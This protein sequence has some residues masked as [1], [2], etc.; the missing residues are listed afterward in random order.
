MGT[1]F[2]IGVKPGSRLRV[3]EDGEG[4]KLEFWAVKRERETLQTF[5]FLPAFNRVPP[6]ARVTPRKVQ[7]K[8]DGLPIHLCRPKP[9]E[10]GDVKDV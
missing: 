4:V 2:V 8:G 6:P 1:F 7:G 5:T 3:R 10:Q 9:E